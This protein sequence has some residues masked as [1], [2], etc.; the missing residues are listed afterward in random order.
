MKYRAEI[1]DKIQYLFNETKFNDHQ[2]HCVIRF[3]NKLDADIL[4]KSLK[5]LLKTVPILTCAYKH[6]NGNS[7]WETLSNSKFSDVFTVVTNEGDFKSFTTSKTNGLCGPQI[8]V[9]LYSSDK[10]SL[11]IIMN[12][13]ICDAAGFKQCIYLLS[14]LYLNLMKNPNFSPEC[15]MDGD[16]SIHPITSQIRFFSKIKSLLFH[17]NESNQKYVHLFPLS[18]DDN[19]EPFILTHE[20]STAR[21]AALRDYCKQNNVTLNDTVLAAYYRV[22]AKMLNMKG[23][24]LHI[25][26]MVDMRKYLK[27]KKANSISN[28]SSTVITKI[29]INPTESFKETLTK[30]NKQMTMKKTNYMGMNGFIKLALL[31]K[32]FN[33]SISYSI[34]KK[35]LANPYICMTNIGVLD[36]EKLVFGDSLPINAFMCGSIK[37]RPHFQMAMSSFSNTITF[38]SNLYGS[39][40][41]R[42]TILHFFSLLDEELPQ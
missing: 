28:L 10:D 20:I 38:S 14:N 42:N 33:N 7:Y 8:K 27:D 18:Q 22:L 15:I 35:T 4:E 5:L 24:P 30:V 39:M 3:Y 2:L 29:S 32:L 12:H 25:P 41:D 6:N 11:S 34:A 31:F 19:I 13:M 40:Q 23:K 26:I 37:Y 1:F 16:R 21:Y 36:S 17:N 9:C